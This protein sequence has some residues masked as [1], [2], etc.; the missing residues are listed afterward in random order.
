MR[1][2]LQ[3][4]ISMI[5]KL[6]EESIKALILDLATENE[7]LEKV[8]YSLTDGV[9]VLN[10]EHEIIFL[11][12]AAERMIPFSEDEL[13]EQHLWDVT[14]DIEL[15]T[16]FYKS[17]N[18]A[19]IVK[20][21]EFYIEAG[22]GV[23][24]LSFTFMPLVKSGAIEGNILHVDDITEKK[25]KEARLRR[26][27]NLASLTTLTAGVAH[28]IKNPL[29]SIGIHIQLIQKAL[30]NRQNPDID[31]VE[32][33]LEVV[34]EEVERLNGIIVDFL[35][36]VRPMDL[37][38]AL[39]DLNRIVNELVEFTM[40]EAKDA[41]VDIKEEFAEDLPWI[42]MDEK[43]FKQAMLNI[44][45][46]AIAA[47]PDGGT[48]CIQTRRRGDC[49]E[50]TV[51]DTGIGIPEENLTKIFE[52][53]FTTKEFGSGLGLTLVYKIIKEHRW[54]IQLKSREG[55]GTSFIICMPIP[56]KDKK[57]IEWG[58]NEI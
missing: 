30:K 15:N 50:L 36:A 9:V 11:N 7:L 28:E 48:L 47:M 34:N 24:T 49:I 53:Y 5:S 12:K 37:D 25:S 44:I 20:D 56:Q 39:T 16:F 45:K 10:R 31:N 58:E 57:L 55:E 22:G 14:R 43:Y 13:L 32:K 17:L 52:P 23:R 3:R 40:Y 2:F 46:N 41:G 6:D 18:D 35:F 8:L 4:A 38:P 1:K 51:S 29:G 27:E 54:D 26:A 19:D 33:F 42:S 21:K